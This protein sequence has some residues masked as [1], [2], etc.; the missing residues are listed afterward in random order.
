MSRS[1]TRSRGSRWKVEAPDLV[2]NRVEGDQV[3]VP[4]RRTRAVERGLIDLPK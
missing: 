4:R 3:K 2:T 1:N